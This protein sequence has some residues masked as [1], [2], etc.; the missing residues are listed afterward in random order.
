MTADPT[1]RGAADA[2]ATVPE[3]AGTPAATASNPSAVSGRTV[4]VGST[5]SDTTLRELWQRFRGPLLIVGLVLLTAL[6]YAIASGGITGGPMDPR[7][8]GGNGARA[9]AVLLEE[10][11]VSV[12]RV[13]RLRAALDAAGPE[14]TLLVTVPDLLTR[15]QAERLVS[16]EYD[17]LVLFEPGEMFLEV[18]ADGAVIPAGDAFPALQEPGC[19]LPAAR[20]AGPVDVEG[21][22]YRAVASENGRTASCYG[23]STRGAVVRQV[24]ADGRVLDV[25]GTPISFTNDRLADQGNAALAMNLLGTHDRLVWYIPSPADI[26]PADEPTEPEGSPVALWSLLPERVRLAAVTAALGAAVLMVAAARRLGPVVPEELPVVVRA[27]E[28]AEGR[29]R[30]YR[31]AH[32]RDR[33]ADALVRATRARLARML[34]LPP[35]VGEPELVAAVRART[36]RSEAEV[37]R[38]LGEQNPHDDGELVR[39]ADALDDLEQEVRRS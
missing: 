26:P 1:P 9:L 37:A 34:A 4:A 25:V 30:L 39:L 35:E 32:A 16:A 19:A 33:A 7:S 22:M 15:D 24:R 21:R 2:G 28:A 38:L 20:R 5:S 27:S 14:T 10:R 31:R 29:A 17:H 8:A 36:G 13:D 23:D 12:E 6:G 3:G 11:G 18:T